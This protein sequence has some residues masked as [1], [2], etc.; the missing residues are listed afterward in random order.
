[1]NKIDP[2]DLQIYINGMKQSAKLLMKEAEIL[3]ARSEEIKKQ[4]IE[5]EFEF[6]KTTD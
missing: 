1:M 5:L 2:L 4:A 3:K 6:I